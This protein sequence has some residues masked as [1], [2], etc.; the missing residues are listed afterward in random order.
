[1]KA[2]GN[3]EMAPGNNLM[4]SVEDISEHKTNGRRAFTE[5]IG[6]V[7]WLMSQSSDHAMLPMSSL[8]SLISTP[9]SLG[10]FK[11]YRRH[12]LPFAF[13]AWSFLREEVELRVLSGGAPL[14]QDEWR[15]GSRAWLVC[16]VAPF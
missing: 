12:G 8:Q 11:L 5:A 10:Q 2:L 15:S 14:K 9:M 6:G 13:A 3:D 7:A 1:M 4:V 16:Q